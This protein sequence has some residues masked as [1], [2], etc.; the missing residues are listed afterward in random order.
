MKYLPFLFSLIICG[1]FSC[2]QPIE[3]PT[4]AAKA[5]TVH[6][7]NDPFGDYWYQGK[8]E[9]NSYELEQSRYGELHAG[10]AVLIFVTEDFSKSKQVKLDNPSKVGK[11]KVGIMKMN[12]TRKFNTGIYPYSTMQSVFT[13]R[14]LKAYPNSLKATTS[15]QEWCGHTFMQLNLDK[16]AWRVS[17]QSYFE[18]EG[19]RSFKLKK[20]MLEDEIWNRIR[21]KPSSLPTGEI[22]IIPSAL[23]TR[24]KHT[25]F[26]VMK[27]KAA[28]IEEGGVMTYQVEFPK[29]RRKLSIQFNK[30]FPHEI[31]G[32]EEAAPRG[33]GPNSQL[34]VTKATRKKSMLLDYWSKH[35]NSD[36]H[37]RTELG[38]D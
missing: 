28:M 12:F 8:A 21:I 26:E 18:S 30:A 2:S 29:L 23:H 7:P 11:D 33:F 6:A 37:L 25:S 36:A 4:T 15:S 9:L 35:N 27:A 32:W 1:L 13:P 19:D 31:L 22:N 20:A 17:Q 5:L 24:L 14:D 16:D 34:Q 38:L 3:Q 10:E